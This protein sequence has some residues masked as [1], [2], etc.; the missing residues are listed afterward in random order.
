MKNWKARLT[1]LA[2]IVAAL[3]LFVTPAVHGRLW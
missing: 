1:Q 3:A 2:G